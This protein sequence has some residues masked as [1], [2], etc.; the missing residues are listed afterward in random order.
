[1]RDEHPRLPSPPSLDDGGQEAPPPAA[2]GQSL[3]AHESGGGPQAGPIH[4]Q[5]LAALCLAITFLT[6]LQQELFLLNLLGVVAGAFCLLAR[7]ARG[8]FC[9]CSSWQADSLHSR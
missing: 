4:Y 8:R 3:P 5:A 7:F 2:T 6:Q 9:S 1:M